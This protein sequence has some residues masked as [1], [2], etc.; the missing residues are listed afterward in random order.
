MADFNTIDDLDMDGKVVLT[1]VD[2]NVPVE[3]G[4][5]TD[6]TRIAKIVPTEWVLCDVRISAAARGFGHGAIHMFA[7]DKT[8]IA[9]GSQSAILRFMDSA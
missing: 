2:L 3:N 1:R 5:V 7:E 6:A 8:M 4:Q 9:S